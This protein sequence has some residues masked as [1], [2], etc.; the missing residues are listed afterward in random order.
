MIHTNGR[1]GNFVAQ[2]L[3]T[4]LGGFSFVTTVHGILGLHDKRNILYRAIDIG[5]CRSASAVIA[6]SADTRRRL[7][8]AGAPAARTLCIPNGLRARDL[9]SL[10]QSAEGRAAATTTSRP[11]RICLLGRLSPERGVEDFVAIARRLLSLNQAVEF[12]VAGD[13]PLRGR[14]AY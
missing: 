5:A 10:G 11:V 8:R 4:N 3:S 12:V 13:G 2:T 1:R 6:V 14:M 9:A 7:V